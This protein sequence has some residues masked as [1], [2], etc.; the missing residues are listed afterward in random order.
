MSGYEER[1]RETG[2]RQKILEV[3]TRLVMEKGVKGTSLADIAR[4]AGISKGTLFYHFPT[5][6]ELV[7][8]LTVQHFDRLIQGFLQRMNDIKGEKME[9]VIY[10]GLNLILQ[11]KERGKLNLYLLQEA[12]MGNDELKE[13]FK[14]TYRH[15]R[16]IM[17]GFLQDLMGRE[18]ETD[19]V[20]ALMLVALIDGLIIQWLIEPEEVDVA[21]IARMI[22]DDLAGF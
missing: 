2:N 19:E 22:A 14:E 11:A 15:Y 7:Y 16:R 6:D 3:A 1:D 20:R 4:E 12:F 8:E 17:Q 10:D 21:E 5:K 13:K 9:K 18:G